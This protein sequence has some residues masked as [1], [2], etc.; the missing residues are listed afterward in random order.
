MGGYN[1]FADGQPQSGA[2][3]FIGDKRLKD[4]FLII[5]RNTGSSVF[6]SQIYIFAV[7]A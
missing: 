2:A 1:P 7:T 3:F 5:D 4:I 6:Y